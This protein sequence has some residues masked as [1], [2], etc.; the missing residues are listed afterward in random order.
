MGSFFDGVG[1]FLKKGLDDVEGFFGGGPQASQP[2]QPQIPH[3]V[4]APAPMQ[5][6]QGIQA[7]HMNMPGSAAPLP[8]LHPTLPQ[9]PIGGKSPIQEF[10]DWA[11]NNIF[12]PTV[13]TIQR[14]INTAESA[15]AG[16]EGLLNTAS[17]AALGHNTQPALNQTQQNINDALRG[18]NIFGGHPIDGGQNSFIPNDNAQSLTN[19]ATFAKG[20]LTTGGQLAPWFVG[21]PGAK[22]AGDAVGAVG[23]GVAQAFGTG[24]HLGGASF[25]GNLAGQ[26]GNNI[27]GSQHGVDLNPALQAGIG[28]LSAGFF[29]DAAIHAAPPLINAG[30]HAGQNIYNAAADA[31]HEAIANRIAQ[32]GGT[33]TSMH[34]N[35]F[36]TDAVNNV[37]TDGR[38]V[39]NY[40][41]QLTKGKDIGPVNMTRNE[42][43]EM[44]PLTKDAANK[45]S[46]YRSIYNDS[47]NAF[48]PGQH[49]L[50]HVPIN[51]VEPGFFNKALQLHQA[52]TQGGYHAGP[53]AESFEDFLRNGP[54]KSMQDNIIHENVASHKSADEYRKNL[55]DGLV[56]EHTK[57]QGT[58]L[59]NKSDNSYDQTRVSNNSQ[60]YRDYYKEYGKAPTRKAITDMVDQLIAGKDGEYNADILAK[61]MDPHELEAHEATYAQLQDREDG[62][63]HVA[64]DATPPEQT[65]AIPEEK[66]FTQPSEPTRVEEAAQNVEGLQEAIKSAK[67]H[68]TD[69]AYV[70]EL[71]NRLKIEKKVI[72]LSKPS[73]AE[74]VKGALGLDETNSTP[75]N[76]REFSQETIDAATKEPPK[77]NTPEEN[78]RRNPFKSDI[79]DP[80]QGKYDMAIQ[81]AQKVEQDVRSK[82]L[83]A[84]MS[85]KKLPEEVRQQFGQYHEGTLKS[86]NPKLQAKIEQASKDWQ[87]VTDTI[88]GHSQAL[89]G[90]TNYLNRYA[91]HP[92][93]LPEDIETQPING[94][95]KD[96]KGLNSIERKHR[97]I[98]DG[99][100]AGLSF[101][102]DYM[103]VMKKYAEGSARA[104]KKQAL[105]RGFAL[106][107]S[108]EIDK[109]G[110]LTLGT[111]DVLPLSKAGMKAA[112]GVQHIPKSTN[113][114]L[115]GYRAGTKGLIQ[116][117]LAHTPVHQGN[118]TMRAVP[119]LVLTGHPF[120]GL[121]AFAGGTLGMFNGHYSSSVFR[122]AVK[123][124]TAAKAA[125]IGMKYDTSGHGILWRGLTPVHDQV[126][127][128]IIHDLEKKGTPLNSAE[129][130]QAGKAGNNMMA[131]MNF[132]ASHVSPSV[133]RAIG[134]VFLARQFTPSKFARLKQAGTD[135]LQNDTGNEA[136]GGAPSSGKIVLKQSIGGK[137]A[138]AT[139]VGNVVASTALIAGM[140]YAFKQKSDDLKDILIRSLL[141]PAVPTPIKD[142]KGNNQEVHLLATDTSDV[143]KLLGIKEVRQPDGHLGI[144]WNPNNLPTT[145]AD[146]FKAR[147][148]PIAGDVLK[149]ATNSNY[150]NKPLYDPNADLPTR[151]TQAGTTLVTGSLPIPL[152]NLAYT[153]PV[154]DTVGTVSPAAKQILDANTAG[155]NAVTNTGLGLVGYT[156][157]NDP[158]VGKG[159]EST[160]HY[161]AIAAAKQGLNN[162]EADAFD[163]A[164]G[165][166]KNPVTGVYDVM[167][168]ANDTR[169]KATAL[170]DQPKA[171]DAVISM[172]LKD[173][174]NGQ[175]IDPL[176]TLS[177]DQI[178]KYEQYEAMAPGG[179]D[180][181][182]WVQDNSDWYNKSF[183]NARND[184]FN[185][186]PAGDPNRPQLQIQPPKTTTKLD[187]ILAAYDTTTDPSQ[188]SALFNNNPELTKYFNAMA[189]Y[190]N[191]MRV[192]QGYDPLRTAPVADASTQKF[193]T[194]YFAADA[195]MKKVLRNSNPEAY[196]AMQNY[197]DNNSRY[198]LDKQAGLDQLIG[199]GDTQ[200]SA[201]GQKYLK[202]VFNLGQYGVGK[203]VDA[204]GNTTY[205]YYP[206]TNKAAGST[207]G[208]NAAVKITQG[209]SAFKGIGG[210][211]GNG[212]SG[213]SSKRQKKQ[214]LRVKHKRDHFV[215]L[216][217]SS[218]RSPVKAMKIAHEV[219]YS[220][221]KPIK[222][223]PVSADA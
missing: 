4:N 121:K 138:R 73:S 60:F 117:L 190:T 108:G 86:D 72:K 3:P 58:A 103:D 6:P 163:I 59:I 64:A 178:I 74:E 142:A 201:P 94:A 26:A 167:P 42:N 97:T 34:Q 17:E 156:M 8:A 111:N 144:T 123:D 114:L 200:N 84:E 136:V 212:G 154:K 61:T 107:D 146:Y 162:K 116:S 174:A 152:Q 169:A 218:R 217:A 150:A 176:Y 10:G 179:A 5:Q 134:D 35:L 188:K 210:Y 7:P 48:E 54:E 40:A 1:S 70:N 56:S 37:P 145:V 90:N 2:S 155:G 171:L 184:Y 205:D 32:A 50:S 62:L 105:R 112:N 191:K 128:S 213:G 22:V 29:G 79:K 65:P 76:P 36:N 45:L 91:P 124:G 68:G 175:K 183:Q 33:N 88:H 43:G 133:A 89:G 16:V 185:S 78:T 20:A 153:S 38:V 199:K 187:A 27:D 159:N 55:I 135:F 157:K 195:N 131:Q 209:G 127:R 192:A 21:G 141:D 129:A 158:T 93:D 100:N 11:N 53:G 220:R 207:T 118:V 149:V 186:L 51:E 13:S 115:R 69:P 165:T 160:Q 214:K 189:D 170:L 130:R 132:E 219:G 83:V 196:I 110:N 31:G 109:T 18:N 122:D 106:A 12:K 148:A 208:A 193:M 63:N 139:I 96:F 71:Q 113:I 172:N 126:A 215:Y 180:R 223:S 119:G 25:I 41:T 19:P 66:K 85:F 177:R 81:N 95:G 99:Q 204:N 80:K 120:A 104:L 221:P 181:T 92:W 194:D 143:S 202:D 222:I 82:Y 161:G 39:D 24:L 168:N 23:K 57:G 98:E 166:K 151:L 15:G 203:G 14:G 147:L 125:Q 67:D 28:G 164:T 46:A 211:N 9:Q 101:S 47:Y 140:G 52:Q 206:S 87:A 75:S 49:P 197:E 30:V 182:K 198:S 137:Y 216:K 173:Q 44:T 77:L 102:G